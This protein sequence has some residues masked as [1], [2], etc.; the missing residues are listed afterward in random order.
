[1]GRLISQMGF[2]QFRLVGGN[3]DHVGAAGGFERL[4]QIARR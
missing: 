1:M 4:A 3:G 2:S